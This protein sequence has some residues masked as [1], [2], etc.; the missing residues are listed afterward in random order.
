LFHGKKLN[1]N[2]QSS[3]LGE[4][5]GIVCEKFHF[6]YPT[7][8]EDSKKLKTL[9]ILRKMEKIV[10]LAIFSNFEVEA[11]VADLKISKSRRTIVV[12]NDV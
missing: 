1:G 9:E 2:F 11:G 5:Q 8:E 3:F 4:L 7:I 10:F 6:S 12:S